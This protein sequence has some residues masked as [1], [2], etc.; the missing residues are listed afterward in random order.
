MNVQLSIVRADIREY[1]K[2]H[3]W[4][5]SNPRDAGLE[6]GPQPLRTDVVTYGQKKRA[7]CAGHPAQTAPWDDLPT[8]ITQVGRPNAGSA[9]C[10]AGGSRH[11]CAR[12][13]GTPTKPWGC[14]AMPSS[15]CVL[16]TR[17]L[18]GLWFLAGNSLAHP[19]QTSQRICRIICS[20]LH[21]LPLRRAPPSPGSPSSSP[22]LSTPAA[23]STRRPGP[24]AAPGAPAVP[25]DYRPPRSA[26]H[27]PPVVPSVPIRFGI[28]PTLPLH[29][30][31]GARATRRLSSVGR[32]SHS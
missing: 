5:E 32:A 29:S 18:L 31:L 20:R 14:A 15:G 24:S 4:K 10:R 1:R 2:K 7:A 3:R 22:A 12:I 8:E 19:L 28:T 30:C 9:R 27:H 26:H 11:Q 23:R 6:S 25:H 21:L 13:A 16:R 17:S